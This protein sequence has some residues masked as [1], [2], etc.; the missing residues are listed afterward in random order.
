MYAP[1]K[2]MGRILLLLPP[3]SKNTVSR[4]FGTY[5]EEEVEIMVHVV[6]PS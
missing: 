4:H 5:Q 6:I 3:M 1:S 2:I